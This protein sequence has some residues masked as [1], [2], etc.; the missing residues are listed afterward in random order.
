MNP[1]EHSSLVTKL[2]Y[3]IFFQIINT[4]SKLMQF[5]TTYKYNWSREVGKEATMNP[6]L[7]YKKTKK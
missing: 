1:N 3:C 6:L 5:V 2:L 7:L 4:I